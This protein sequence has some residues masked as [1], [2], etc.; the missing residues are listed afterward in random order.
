MA[1]DKSYDIMSSCG[2]LPKQR[3]LGKNNTYC[4]TSAKCCA[5][6]PDVGLGY[7]TLA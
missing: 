4:Y 2:L 3:I 7:P 5:N 1:Q 6:T